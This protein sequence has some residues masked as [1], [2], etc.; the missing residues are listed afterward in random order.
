MLVGSFLPVGLQ[1]HYLAFLGNKDVPF[2][3]PNVFK[4]SWGYVFGLET[5]GLLG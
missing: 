2:L 4:V 1:S 5:E 3:W